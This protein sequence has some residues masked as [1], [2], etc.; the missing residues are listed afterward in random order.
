MNTD[1]V[2]A[3]SALEHYEYC[4]RQCALIHV[5]SV[6]VDN[7]HTV[8]GQY[9]HRRADS[10]E[11]K[12]QKGADVLR[13]IPLWSELHGL[14]GRADLVEISDTGAITPIEYKIGRRHGLAADI[15][16]CAQV[17]CLE[18][19]SGTTI[20]HGYLWL[21][22]TRRRIKIVLDDSLRQATFARI[23]AVRE[24][25]TARRLPPA[26]NDRRCGQCQFRGHCLPGIV[27]HAGEVADY[28]REELLACGS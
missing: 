5:D 22:T 25:L 23:S 3:I 2:V 8:R 20:P 6:W 12:R 15:Q 24:V 14:T 27:A 16:L 7:A 9:G 11:T 1:P 4:P 21:S 18:E 28:I 13:S 17:I 26:P 19:M 10:G